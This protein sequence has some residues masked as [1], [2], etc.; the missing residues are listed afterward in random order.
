MHQPTPCTTSETAH[1]SRLDKPMPSHSF[2]IEEIGTTNYPSLVRAQE[3]ALPSL[4][5]ANM[6]CLADELCRLVARILTHPLDA[7][8]G[9]SLTIPVASLE[10]A[11]EEVV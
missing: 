10:C 3:A 11:Q 6:T 2:Q 4:A 7:D 9:R 1:R 5:D 8:H